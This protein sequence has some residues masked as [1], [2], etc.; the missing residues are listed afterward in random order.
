[1]PNPL[2][3]Y[4]TYKGKYIGVDPAH[5]DVVYA[6]RTVAN[7]WE[8]ITLVKLPSNRY[9]AWFDAAQ[10]FLTIDDLGNL[11]TRTSAQSWEQHCIISPPSEYSDTPAQLYQPTHGV[12]LEVEAQP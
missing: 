4:A 11:G 12:I 10:R 7:G 8:A 1:M 6:D 3:I 2:K 9:T 5:P